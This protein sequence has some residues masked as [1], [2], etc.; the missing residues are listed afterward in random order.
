[1]YKLELTSMQVPIHLAPPASHLKDTLR[2]S[3][4]VLL[5]GTDTSSV[6]VQAQPRSA[7]ELSLQGA[8]FKQYGPGLGDK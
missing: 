2:L 7:G 3:V 8:A 6:F 1:M 5:P 4:Q